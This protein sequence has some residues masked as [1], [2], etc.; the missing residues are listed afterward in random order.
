MLYEQAVR[1]LRE[2]EQ[3]NAFRDIILAGLL[4]LVDPVLD[5]VLL[6]APF[7]GFLHEKGIS[8]LAVE[9]ID[10]HCVDPAFE[11]FVFGLKTAQCFFMELM[12]IGIAFFEGLADPT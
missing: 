11:L 6:L 8:D 3:P 12:S 10:I 1:V 7:G 9:F 2:F 4:Q 5:T